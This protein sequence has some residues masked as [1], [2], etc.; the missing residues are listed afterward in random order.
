MASCQINMN[1]ARVLK[2][3]RQDGLCG[4]FKAVGRS[5]HGRLFTTGYDTEYVRPILEKIWKL[6]SSITLVE[7]GANVGATESD[8]FYKFIT[9]HFPT[10]QDSRPL[11]CRAVLVEPVLDLY[12]Q[13]VTNYAKYQG[14][15]CINAAIAESA[16]VKRFYRF[17]S[18]IDLAAFGL[19]SFAYQLGSF[20]RNN[21]V[22]ACPVF[23]DEVTRTAFIKANVLESDIPCATLQGILDAEGIAHVDLL[24]I[25]AE[26]YDYQILKT[27]NFSRSAPDYINYERTHLRK[28]QAACRRLLLKSGYALFDH[29]DDTLC[30][31]GKKLT[32]IEN[33]REQIY[34][35]WLESIY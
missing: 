24:V 21:V 35:R 16:G 2:K 4:A 27:I 33:V 22:S 11:K 10:K 23:P 30:I 7:I 25:D 29:N 9:E 20:D 3:V 13:L 1:L 34:I 26:G 5:I 28:D 15:T 19:P 8:P 14:I 32:Y 6:K 17:R 31:R 12:K 18:D